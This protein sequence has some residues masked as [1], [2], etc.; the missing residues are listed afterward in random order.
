MSWIV[1]IHCQFYTFDLLSSDWLES[2]F[3]P[4]GYNQSILRTLFVS[5]LSSVPNWCVG[6]DWLSPVLSLFL[7]CD[8]PPGLFP[9]NFQVLG[10]CLLYNFAG[11][12]LVIFTLPVPGD[13]EVIKSIAKPCICTQRPNTFVIHCIMSAFWNIS[14]FKTLFFL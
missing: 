9:T 13:T 2:I 4:I 12:L 3:H 11:A 10:H 5:N 1:I 14:N 6:S 7:S 8:P